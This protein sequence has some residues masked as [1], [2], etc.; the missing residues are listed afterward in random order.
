MLCRHQGTELT[1]TEVLLAKYRQVIG[2][3][4]AKT[5]RVAI[6]LILSR[7]KDDDHIRVNYRNRAL[8]TMRRSEG[9]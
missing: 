5:N 4:K 2:D 6:T 7:V 3:L 1:R 9:V 8:E